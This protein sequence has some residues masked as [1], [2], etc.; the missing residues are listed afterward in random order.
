M[1]LKINA[2]LFWIND[3][4][5]LNTSFDDNNKKFKL[6]V[7]NVSPKAAERLAS[8]FGIKMKSHP[9]KPEYGLHFNAKSL[10]AWEF[11]DDAGNVVNPSDIG[12]GTKAVVEV[13][14]SYSHKFEKAHGKGPVVNSRGGVVITELVARE[15]KTS[16]EEAEAL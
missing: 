4:V 6:T 13:T 2:Q 9:E 14:G 1:S 15:A 7:C 11:K 5:T 16:E 3:A 10:Y 8:D 12:N